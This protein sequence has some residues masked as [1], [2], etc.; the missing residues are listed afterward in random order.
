M[1]SFELLPAGVEPVGL[2]LPQG[3]GTPV[4]FR[5]AAWFIKVRWIVI[6]LFLAAGA[7]GNLLS[8]AFRGIGLAL[9]HRGLWLLAGLAYS[10]C[11]TRGFREQPPQFDFRET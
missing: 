11:K 3:L 5:N 9:P 6:G 7:A 8:G 10:G 2:P 1:T 4:L